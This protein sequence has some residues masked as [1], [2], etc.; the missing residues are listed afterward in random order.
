MS[1]STYCSQYHSTTIILNLMLFLEKENRE[2][3]DNRLLKREFLKHYVSPYAAYRTNSR[4]GQ[5]MYIL[6]I[7]EKTKF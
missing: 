1:N 3:P 6:Q 2:Q 7:L 5:K 4:Y